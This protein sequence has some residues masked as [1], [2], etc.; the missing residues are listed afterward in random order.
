MK[1]TLDVDPEIEPGGDQQDERHREDL[2]G[3][4]LGP[5]ADCGRQA[6]DQVLEEDQGDLL[7]ARMAVVLRARAR[8][9]MRP[10]SA[11]SMAQAG[12]VSS[13]IRVS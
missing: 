3:V 13:S 7:S 12:I 5:G 2:N 11:H 4:E 1:S 10:P 8:R 9:P 6:V